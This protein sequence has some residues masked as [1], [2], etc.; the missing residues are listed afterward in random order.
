MTHSS[1]SI[2]NYFANP[3]KSTIG[4]LAVM[5]LACFL[6]SSS[7]SAQNIQFTQGSISSG[8]DNTIQIPIVSY[9]GRGANLPVTLYYSSRVWRLGTL[10]TVNDLSYY[11]TITEAIY[12]EHSTAGWKTS[13]DLPIVE[14]PKEQD[15]YYYT[16]K[17]FCFVCNSN[18]RRFRVARVYIIMPDGSK[19][20]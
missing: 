10:A 20:E 13:L 8:L 16:G 4:R 6:A 12:G 19:H 17:Q 3:F 5:V 18:L 15:Q 2:R 9:P 1:K 7:V 14:W 11:T